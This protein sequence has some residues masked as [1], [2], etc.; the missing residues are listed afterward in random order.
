MDTALFMYKIHPSHV[1]QL[2]SSITKIRY[3]IQTIVLS[4]PV[5]SNKLIS[6]KIRWDQLR[7]DIPF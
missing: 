4:E 2:N 5:K 7:T 6:F 1:P 3:E